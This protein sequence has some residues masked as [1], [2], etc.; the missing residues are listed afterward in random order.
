MVSIKRN[1]ND[2]AKRMQPKPQCFVL[3]ISPILSMKWK[4]RKENKRHDK[5]QFHVLHFLFYM[6]DNTIKSQDALK[7]MLECQLK[8]TQYIVYVFTLTSL[9]SRISCLETRVVCFSLP[10][11]SG[12]IV[13]KARQFRHLALSFWAFYFIFGSKIHWMEWIENKIP[14]K[15][16]I[17]RAQIDGNPF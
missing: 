4:K 12:R 13:S 8:P 16:E 14:K 2:L 3:L 11:F 10:F 5:R 15:K 6:C 7:F 9:H 17:R 1:Q